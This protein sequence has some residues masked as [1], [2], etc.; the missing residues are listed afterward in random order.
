MTRKQTEQK[1][2]DV[3]YLLFACLA[4]SGGRITVKDSTITN[5]SSQAAHL[6]VLVDREEGAIDATVK[7]MDIRPRAID[8]VYYE[9][10]PEETPAVS[11]VH[12]TDEDTDVAI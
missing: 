11:L 2:K 6:A 7:L 8:Y 4:A 12:L 5:V 3:T 10:E 1:L 9:P